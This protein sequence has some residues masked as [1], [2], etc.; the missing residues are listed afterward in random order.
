M[1]EFL[2]FPSSRVF[3]VFYA[4]RQLVLC[5]AVLLC[6]AAVVHEEPNYLPHMMKMKISKSNSS[7]SNNERKRNKIISSVKFLI[8]PNEE[9]RLN[10]FAK[11]LLFFDYFLRREREKGSLFSVYSALLS[12]H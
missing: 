3:N 5:L 7:S 1:N 8:N 2:L 9:K 11:V 12:T 6:Y 10:L 4:R